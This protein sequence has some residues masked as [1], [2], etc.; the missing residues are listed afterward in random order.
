[1]VNSGLILL[2]EKLAGLLVY[3]YNM[4]PLFERGKNSH[5]CAYCNQ[6]FTV[7]SVVNC[8]CLRVCLLIIAC[9][10]CSVRSLCYDTRNKII[11]ILF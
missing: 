8:Y 9:C 10:E 4:H 2:P 3:V 7:V 6:I 11:L 5:S 1:M